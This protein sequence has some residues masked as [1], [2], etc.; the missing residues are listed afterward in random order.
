[1]NYPLFEIKHGPLG[2]DG[3]PET[4]KV[5][6]VGDWDIENFPDGFQLGEFDPNQSI[7]DL[8]N[9][10]VLDRLTIKMLQ[11]QSITMHN[12]IKKLRESLD[13]ANDMIDRFMENNRSISGRI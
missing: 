2:S 10:A 3:L 5:V 9:Q 1:M 4:V 11:E 12:Q 8:R 7:L 6:S 13:R